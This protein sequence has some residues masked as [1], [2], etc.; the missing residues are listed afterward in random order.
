MANKKK[1]SKRCDPVES[2]VAA[3]NAGKI[4]NE[5]LMEQALP[6][7]HER[8]QNRI[9]YHMTRLAAK[10]P[11]RYHISSPHRRELWDDAVAAYDA[12]TKRPAKRSWGKKYKSSQLEFL[13]RVLF[14]KEGQS[15]LRRLPKT[16]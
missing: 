16:T 9:S 4:S 13:F 10:D 2:L 14:S 7:L 5:Q 6:W 12:E 11:A 15:R 1:T 3:F 8:R